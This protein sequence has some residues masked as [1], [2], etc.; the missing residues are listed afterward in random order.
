MKS[1]L[2]C[3]LGSRCDL[4]RKPLT[5]KFAFVRYTL[6]LAGKQNNFGKTTR[7]ENVELEFVQHLTQLNMNE[8]AT[9][10]LRSCEMLLYNVHLK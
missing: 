7:F 2:N 10:K 3:G 5:C 6:N 9:L 4:T 1:K 8:M